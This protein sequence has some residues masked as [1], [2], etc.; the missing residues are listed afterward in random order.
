MAIG[1]RQVKVTKDTPWNLPRRD[2]INFSLSICFSIIIGIISTLN[3]LY[4]PGEAA[5]CAFV[6]ILLDWAVQ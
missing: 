2:Q 6:L 1:K 5:E 4:L 3:R